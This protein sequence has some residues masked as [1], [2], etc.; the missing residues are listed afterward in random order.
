MAHPATVSEDDRERA[1]RLVADCIAVHWPSAALVDVL[2]LRGDA[3]SRRYLRCRLSGA[4][5]SPDSLVVM[6][7]E[8]SSVSISS[9]E[10]AVFGTDGPSELPF[11][12]VWRFLSNVTDAVP[13]IH[14]QAADGS[15]LVLE[16][17]GDS[18][19]WDEARRASASGPSAAEAI[20]AR[21]LDLLADLQER[22]T[23]D[24]SGCYAFRQN[25]DERLFSWEFEHFI[26][27]GLHEPRPAALRACRN[28][29][30]AA[31]SRLASLPRVFCHRDFHAW[32]IH[33]QHGRLRLF[34][35]Q[36]ALRAPAT[37]DVA[38]LLTDRFTPELVDAD[39]ARRLVTRF[40]DRR[41]LFDAQEH[42][43]LCAFQR[44]LKVI[45]RFHFLAE[46]KGKPAYLDMLP[47][48]VATARAIAAEID[49]APVTRELLES[50]LKLDRVD[51][52]AGGR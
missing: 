9:D 41:R 39:M 36:D 21:A 50:N 34:D 44:V 48:V 23:D 3:S 35:F 29:L 7:M 38:S 33:V 10:L 4:D 28:E 46:V 17:V 42:F 52:G 25:F 51:V 45:G 26:E 8:G 11:V 37:Y 15:G 19:L 12:N 6:L 18:T 40:A 43:L 13:A 27:Y 24:G 49:F 22:A 47:R 20:F 31:A 32:N 2:P 16:D 30:A 1:V 5:G 14:H